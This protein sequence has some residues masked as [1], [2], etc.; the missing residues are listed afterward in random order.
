MKIQDYI[1]TG[2]PSVSFLFY[3]LNDNFL[4]KKK[5]RTPDVAAYLACCSF[6]KECTSF[7]MRANHATSIK[8]VILKI[9]AQ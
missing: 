2:E 5:K 9:A 3:I 6:Q 7:V 4:K 1:L 8:L